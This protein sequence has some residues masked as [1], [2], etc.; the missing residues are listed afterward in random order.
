MKTM[1]RWI[2]W[3]V[4]C[5]TSFTSLATDLNAPP[6]D[7]R[8]SLGLTEVEK[9]SFLSEM[10]QMLASIQGI[11]SGIAKEDSGQIIKFARYSGNRM[12]RA[13]P[14]SIK[15][16]TPM[17]FKEIGAPTHM[18]FEELVVRAETDDMQTL[19][20]LTGRIMKQCLACHE[21]FK[22]N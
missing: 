11:I 21:M 13:T 2:L 9:A 3:L 15:A 17:A 14:L 16:K 20:E 4:L 1:N 8:I 7:Q 12:A 5:M 6:L 18:M 22:T 19:T 10:R